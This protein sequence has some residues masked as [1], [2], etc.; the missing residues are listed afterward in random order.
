MATTTAPTAA[1]ASGPPGCTV[2]VRNLEES[3]KIPVLKQSLTA[4]FSQYGTIIDVIARRSLKAKG[5]AFVVFDKPESA[6]AAIK[7]VQAFPLFSKPMVL[8]FSKS[9]SDATVKREAGEESAE[10]EAHKRRRLAEKERR[11]AQAALE[12]QR[13]PAAAAPLDPTKPAKAKPSGGLKSTAPSTAPQI[14]DEYLPPHTTLFLRELPDDADAEMLSNLF[15]RYDAFKE[16][17]MVPGR[18]GIAFVEF[19]TLEGAISAKE[20]MGGMVLGGNVVRV[21]YQR[22]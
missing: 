4:I 19:E 22:Q 17:R 7:E 21:T 14:P 18:K 16:V 3:I 13:R 15:G 2:Y 5:Q 12:S 20:G 9:R 6:E 1:V 10:F 8:A 11:E